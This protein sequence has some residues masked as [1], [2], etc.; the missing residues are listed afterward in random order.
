MPSPLHPSLISSL[1]K[2]N[3]LTS[4]IFLFTVPFGKHALAPKAPVDNQGHNDV[5]LVLIFKCWKKDEVGAVSF[6]NTGRVMLLFLR[7]L[8]IFPIKP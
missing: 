8:R 2:Q 1:H 4:A 6:H 3:A 7:P 5:E